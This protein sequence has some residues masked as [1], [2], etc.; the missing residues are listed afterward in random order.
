MRPAVGWK[1]LRSV[2]YNSCRDAPSSGVE[3]LNITQQ[4]MGAD[5]I[6]SGV[7]QAENG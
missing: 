2:K 7:G 3:Q 1:R 5:A 6:S 4:V